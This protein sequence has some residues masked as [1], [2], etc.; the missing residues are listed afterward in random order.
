M[1]N[2]AQHCILIYIV[3]SGINRNKND[4]M[5][6]ILQKTGFK[7]KRNNYRDQ[8]MNPQEDCRPDPHGE[9]AGFALVRIAVTRQLLPSPLSWQVVPIQNLRPL[10]PG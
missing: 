7:W 2:S 6:V 1:D 3:M 5:L 9:S 8:Q 4:I 10:E